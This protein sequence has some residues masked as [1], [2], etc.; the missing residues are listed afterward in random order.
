[1]IKFKHIYPA[2]AVLGF[3]R[4]WSTPRALKS[5]KKAGQLLSQN[6]FMV[7]AGN[8]AG[9]PGAAISAA[10][11]NGGDSLAILETS[12]LSDCNGYDGYYYLQTSAHLKHRCIARI[13]LAAIVIGGGPGS[14]EIVKNFTALKKPVLLLQG[15]GGICAEANS[16][17]NLR[18]VNS[19]RAAVKYSTILPGFHFPVDR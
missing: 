11:A 13:C 7:V 4:S 14:L 9:T 8:T 2:I 17:K 10:R 12:Q 19:I 3:A 5:A 15:S 18:W 16:G 6:N 1:M